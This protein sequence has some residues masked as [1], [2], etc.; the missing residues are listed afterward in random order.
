MA[1][2]NRVTPYGEIVAS[3]LR[4]AWMGNRGCLHHG[5][6]IVRPWN[7]K[8]WIICAL[9]FKGWIAPKWAPGRWTA[10]FFHDEAVAFAAGHRP[11]ALCRRADYL[12]YRAAL[13][14]T[15]ADE[16]DAV[17]HGE[18]LGG[19]RKRLHAIAW[20]DLPNGTFVDVG[21][22]PCAVL[23]DRL[24]RW[25][26]ASGYGAELARPTRGDARVLTPPASVQVLL[27]GYPVQIDRTSAEA[28]GAA[29][30]G[31]GSG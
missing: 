3:A 29:T 31:V 1:H 21:G 2:R 26:A 27:A 4:G 17:L 8:R 22:A 7:G 18:R 28:L 6:D 10:L 19:R 13:D 11:C 30:R 20:R 14:A 16:I 23:G 24:R 15:G 9:E 12:R 5:H 25:D